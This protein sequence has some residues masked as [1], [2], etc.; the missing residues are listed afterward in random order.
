MKLQ[1]QHQSTNQAAF[2]GRRSFLWSVAAALS[3]LPFF[4]AWFGRRDPKKNQDVKQGDQHFVLLDK[5][6]LQTGVLKQKGGVRKLELEYQK[7]VGWK[8]QEEQL[9]FYLTRTGNGLKDFQ[10]FSNLCPHVG[11]K[12]GYD[13][14]QKIFRCPCHQGFFNHQGEVLEGPAKRGL[15][16]IPFQVDAEGLSVRMSD[17][18]AQLQGTSSE[19]KREGL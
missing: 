18:F 8:V 10:L 3:A 5:A 6:E 14:Q 17:Y 9:G 7:Q 13:S 19:K 15:F 11:C 4:K 16:E 12:V 2:K 1:A